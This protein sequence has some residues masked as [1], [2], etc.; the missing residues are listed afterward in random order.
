MH[1]LR[2]RPLR[3]RSADPRDEQG[4]VALEAALVFMFLFFLLAGVIDVS[5]L[6]KDTYS[7]SS[8]A[9]SGARMGAADPMST[10]F[11]RTAAEQAVSA[12]TDLDLTRVT[13]IWVYK[14]NALTGETLVPGS[15]PV[16]SCVKYTVAANGTLSAPTGVWLARNACASNTVDVDSVGVQVRYRH[17]AQVMFAN[18]QILTERVTMRLEQIPTTQPCLSIL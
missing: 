17:K 7:V 12:M 14:A 18:N 8:A 15:C 9:R 11:A 10:T 3:A 16:A 5:M 2:P 1:R 6:F 13:E 4:A